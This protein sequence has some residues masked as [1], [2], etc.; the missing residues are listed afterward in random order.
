MFMGGNCPLHEI[1]TGSEGPSL[2]IIRDSYTDSLIPFLLEDF[3]EIHVIDL[4][5]YRMSVADYIAQ[6]GFDKVLV[7]IQREH[8]RHRHKPLFNEQ[9]SN[10]PP[11]RNSAG[12]L[13]LSLKS[14]QSLCKWYIIIL[15]SYKAAVIL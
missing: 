5:Y 9:V 8:L 7:L 6:N 3:S 10:K 2:L 13:F 14:L 4:R 12:G 11:R 15:Y 1:V